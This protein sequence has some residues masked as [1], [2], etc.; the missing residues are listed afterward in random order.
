MNKNKKSY[1]NSRERNL[2]FKR[3][4]FVLFMCIVLTAVLAITM[5][6]NQFASAGNS[7]QMSNND[8]PEYPIHSRNYTD[9]G[10]SC[11]FEGCHDQIPQPWMDLTMIEETS[12]SVKYTIDG[13]TD[14]WP[15]AEGWAVLDNLENNEENGLGPGE[16]TI[17]K[18][19][20]NETYTVYWVDANDTLF[21]R[22]G[23]NFIEI[24]VNKSTNS[25]PSPP[26]ITGPPSGYT[27]ETLTYQ[28]V[29]ED[30]DGDNVYYKIDWG[31][32]V[33]DEWFGDFPSGQPQTKSHIWSEPGI[34]YIT[35][36]ARD[37]KGAESGWITPFEVN[38]TIQ[39][40][41]PSLK[42]RLKMASIGKIRVTFQNKGEGD[43]SDIDYIVTA[44]GGLFR[45]T[46][47]IDFTANGTIDNLPP[48]GKTLV[49]IPHESL[50]LRFCAAKVTITAEAGG[51]T[52]I[53]NQLVVVL[54]R[55]VFARPILLLQP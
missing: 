31:D 13:Q 22:G 43:L 29:S 55:F 36:K 17:Q 46:K 49:S 39:P 28:F 24:I 10:V 9:T 42:I 50:R 30:P 23:S 48:G 2:L 11:N 32:G 6:N 35:A 19:E 16:F 3:N 53:H 1:N 8:V 4:H 18:S 21:G 26:E 54:G 47:R 45:I 44:Q 25:P 5:I 41:E 20:E 27:G 52:Y 15:G 33:V 34:Y 12:S 40:F 7:L 37:T 14:T 38:I 51:E